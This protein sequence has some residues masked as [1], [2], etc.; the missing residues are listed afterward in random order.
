MDRRAALPWPWVAAL[1]VAVVAA[2]ANGVSAPPQFDDGP[3]IGGTGGELRPLL[4][5]TFRVGAA[6]GAGPA[7]TR[8]IN[9][10]IHLF[11]VVAALALARR[12]APAAGT[13]ALVAGGVL[14]GLHPLATEAVTYL[15]GR[16]AALST[17]FV[18]A[19]TLAWVHGVR[20]GSRGVQ[21]AS[22]AL[23]VLGALVKETVALLPLGLLAWDLTVEG[24]PWRRAWVRFA[25]WGVLWAVLGVAALA[26]D[27]TFRLLLGVVGQRP[28]GLA[29]AHQLEGVAWVASRTVCVHRLSIDPGLGLVAPSLPWVVAGGVLVAALAWAARAGRGLPAFAAAWALLWLVLPYL[30][31]PRTDVLNERHAYVVLA[32]AGPALGVALGPALEALH[33]AVR[34]AALGVLAVG[35]GGATAARNR[36]YQSELALWTRTVEVSPGNP[37]AHHN[38]GVV[39]ERAGR[40]RLARQAYAD[41]VAILPE[42]A[43]AADGLARV[44]RQLGP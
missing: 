11:N 12:A 34:R 15:S 33:P 2:Y 39:H 8:A 37:R 17:T 18:L 5:W 35:L 43:S 23:L 14:F 28:L 38:L 41:A 7:G 3:V 40:L 30:L 25:P 26:H 24:T 42:Y 31:L 36:D 4:A 1:L 20:S 22:A 19:A 27:A 32:V 6:V 29:V 21:A 16:S 10:A 13:P 9:V 44:E